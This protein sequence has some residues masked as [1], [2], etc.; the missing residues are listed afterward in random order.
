MRVV[1]EDLWARPANYI[2]TTNGVL[3][4]NGSLVMGTGAAL[5]AVIREPGLDLAA[6]RA[7]RERCQMQDR[8]GNYI[9][10]FLP[11]SQ[12]GVDLFGI[13]QVKFHWRERG[14]LGLIARSAAGL[15]EVAGSMPG[16]DFRLNFPGI[17][18]GGLRREDVEPLLQ[19]LPDNVYICVNNARHRKLIR[20]HGL[21]YKDELE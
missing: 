13:F 16:A 6:G 17:G 19:G 20:Q 4:A 15:A 5:E 7:I 21:P 10:G 11:L 12:P 18:K 3:R 1:Y 2:V 9:Y 14:D 8:R